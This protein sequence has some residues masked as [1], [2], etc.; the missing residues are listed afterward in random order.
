[1]FGGGQ[2]TFQKVQQL[3]EQWPPEKAYRSERKY[4]TDLSEYLDDQLNNSGS[5]SGLLGG[6]GGGLGG[7]DDS[8][9]Y[10]VRTEYGHV[11]ADV[12]V[13][14]DVGI[15]L[16][17][18]LS[19]SQVKKLRGQ[20]ESYRDEFPYVIAC[21]CGIKDMDGWRELKNSYQG[22]ASGMGIDPSQSQGEVVFVHKQKDE[23]KSRGGSTGGGAESGSG[24]L[25]DDSGLF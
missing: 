18:N 6:G 19:N 2:Q 22:Q 17:Y 1:M 23:A 25:F 21:A 8:G 14:D 15:E 11:N 7:V 24:G 4:Q 16:K 5:D 3:V 20:I 9:D 13:D 10:V 12:A